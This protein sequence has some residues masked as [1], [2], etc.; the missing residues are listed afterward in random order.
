[1]SYFWK[2][3]YV[4]R[5]KENLKSV[6]GEEYPARFL[7]ICVNQSSMNKISCSLLCCLSQK[8]FRFNFME[9]LKRNPS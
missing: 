9:V 3:V 2:G 1:M 4:N 5:K 7:C 6:V 8:C